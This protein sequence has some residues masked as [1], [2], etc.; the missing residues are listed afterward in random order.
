MARF[1]LMHLTP[2]ARNAFRAYRD[3]RREC[4]KAERVMHTAF[5]I[6]RGY[7][8]SAQYLAERGEQPG[9]W[10]AERV[11][12]TTEAHQR[13]EAS[14]QA[15]VERGNAAY[16]AAAPL[17]TAEGYEFGWWH[18]GVMRLPEGVASPG[19]NRLRRR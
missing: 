1:V 13:A 6:M 14:W 16:D 4:A 3:A 12:K 19:A 8:Q 11:A 9:E 2:A 7:Q 17:L 10:L 15:T 5:Q 18:T